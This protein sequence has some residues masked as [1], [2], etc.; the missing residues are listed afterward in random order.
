MDAASDI[1][2]FKVG[3]WSPAL[4]GRVFA[5]SPFVA[6][7]QEAELAA[8]AR[9]VRLCFYVGWPVWR[10]IGDHE[11]ALAQVASLHARAVLSRQNRHL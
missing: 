6:R 2:L 11:S 5:C 4:G 3:I 8:L 10:L 7:Q 1:N 9:G